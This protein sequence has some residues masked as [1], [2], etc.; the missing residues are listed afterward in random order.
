MMTKAP[1]S[2]LCGEA[3]R[4]DPVRVNAAN[5]EH[6]KTAFPLAGIEPVNTKRAEK[7]RKGDREAVRTIG[8]T[9]HHAD[10]PQDQ[11][12]ASRRGSRGKRA[13]QAWLNPASSQ[14]SI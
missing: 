10:L 6:D 3:V 8:Q 13:D 2:G 12:R 14:T 11:P 5:Y 7:D 4:G 1:E 9:R